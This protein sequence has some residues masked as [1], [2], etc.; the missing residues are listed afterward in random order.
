[1]IVAGKVNELAS[2]LPAVQQLV[3]FQERAAAEFQ[4]SGSRFQEFQ[5]HAAQEAAFHNQKFESRLTQVDISLQQLTTV[6]DTIVRQLQNA[7]QQPF[8][9]SWS[10][11]GGYTSAIHPST[12][13]VAN[14]S[15]A[16]Q[17]THATT[18]MD[19]LVH[20]T[21]LKILPRF[22]YILQKSMSTPT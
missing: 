12:H 21:H 5:Q 20:A 15:A 17:D 16:A 13:T 19:A 6:C 11:S 10:S 4:T 2:V 8:T 9:T 1:M 7:Q 22:R 18:I 14:T 3:E